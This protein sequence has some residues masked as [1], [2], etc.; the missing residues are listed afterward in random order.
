MTATIATG[1]HKSIRTMLELTG[2]SRPSYEF[3]LV[4]NKTEFSNSRNK[5]AQDRKMCEQAEFLGEGHCNFV[6]EQGNQQSYS[7]CT[8]EVTE[9]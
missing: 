9:R 4:I 2:I 5:K 7:T 6:K 1:E 3:V 8:A